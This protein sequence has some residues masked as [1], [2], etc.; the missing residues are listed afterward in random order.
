MVKQRKRPV[1]S[2]AKG[3]PQI[4]VRLPPE[5]VEATKRAS[6]AHDR[7]GAWLIRRAYREWLVKEG[8]LAENHPTLHT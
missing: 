5:M 7:P 4:G 6:K 2:E 1:Q 8:F 3:N